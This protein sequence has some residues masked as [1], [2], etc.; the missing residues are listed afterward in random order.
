MIQ[1]ALSLINSR[2]DFNKIFKDKKTSP[3]HLD[4]L[5]SSFRAAQKISAANWPPLRGKRTT[6]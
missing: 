6:E 3:T 4:E 1:V 5:F 2:E